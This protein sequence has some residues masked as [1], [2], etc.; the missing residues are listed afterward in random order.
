MWLQ[1]RFALFAANFVRIAPDR[2][3]NQCHQVPNGCKES[4]HPTVREQVK[5]GAHSF[6]RIE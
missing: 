3:A 5:A 1:E 2:L 4:T 6:A